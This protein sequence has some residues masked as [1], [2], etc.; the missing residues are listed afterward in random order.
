MRIVI[1]EFMDEGAVA[2]LAAQ[3]DTCYDKS[4]V[5]QPASLRKALAGADALIVR[6]RRRSI[7]RCWQAAPC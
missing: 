3:H 1:S 7:A 2:R 6:N 5:D 4:L